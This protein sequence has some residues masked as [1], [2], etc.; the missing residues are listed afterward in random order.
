M[1]VKARMLLQPFLDL[2]ML[3]RG[4]IVTDQVQRLALR[5]FRSICL[6]N[7]AIQCGGGAGRN[8]R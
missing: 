3:V 1:N 4:V 5:R 2:G 6:R 7:L 8:A